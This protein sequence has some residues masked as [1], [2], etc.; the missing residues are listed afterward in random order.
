VFDRNG[1]VRNGPAPR[2]LYHLA[3]SLEEDGQL[4]VDTA[5][6]ADPEFLLRV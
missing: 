3:V 1:N 6:E 4:V 2:P 5:V